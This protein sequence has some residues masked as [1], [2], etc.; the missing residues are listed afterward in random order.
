MLKRRQSMIKRQVCQ[1]LTRSAASLL[2]LAAMLLCPIAPLRASPPQESAR[3]TPSG[4][5][6]PRFASLKVNRV[7]VRQGPSNDSAISWVYVRKG[8]PVEIVA[9]QDIW[10]RIRDQ[11]GQLGWVHSRLLEGSRMG[12]VLGTSLR[13]IRARPEDSGRP[14]AWAEPG[15]L[16]RLK[17]C[18]P[19]WCQVESQ[20]GVSGYVERTAIWGLLP[21]ETFD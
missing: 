9:E 21:S 6:V 19:A 3:P 5:P 2:V 17:R 14:A 10:R 15:L 20:T 7:N 18:E 11:K 4:L 12:V 1:A 13:A 8:W 16:V